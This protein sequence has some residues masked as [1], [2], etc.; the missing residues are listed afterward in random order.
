MAALDG[1]VLGWRFRVSP[2]LGPA[3]V[4]LYGL[5]GA[6]DAGHPAN[7]IAVGLIVDIAAAFVGA[8]TGFLFG[9]PRT[10]EHPATTNAVMTT[11]TNLEQ[12]SDWLTKILIALGLVQLGKLASGLDSLAASIADGLGGGSAAKTFALALLVYAATNGFLVGYLWTRIGLSM[13]FR[14]AAELLTATEVIQNPLP[15]AAPPLPPP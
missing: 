5:S 2:L 4:L 12:V 15:P 7:I 8:L 6:F 11:N 10:I 1:G 9:L 13:R 14:Q 3:A